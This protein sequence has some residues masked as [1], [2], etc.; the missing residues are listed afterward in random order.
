[1][2]DPVSGKT[3][4][5]YELAPGTEFPTGRTIRGTSLEY[6][7]CNGLTP[8][9]IKPGTG[10]RRS[11]PPRGTMHGDLLPNRV[12]QRCGH[13]ARQPDR[14]RLP[15]PGPWPT[16][17]RRSPV[18]SDHGGGLLAGMTL[19]RNAGDVRNEDFDGPGNVL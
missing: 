15:E 11:F 2:T 16:R 17:S 13:D 5:C 18:S 6:T 8:R 19:C 4:T 12:G 14:D 10:A 7:T 3:S 1:M 9:V